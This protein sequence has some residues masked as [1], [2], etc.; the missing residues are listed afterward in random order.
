MV[1]EWRSVIAVSPNIGGG[2]HLIKSAKL[3]MCTQKHYNHNEDGRTAPGVRGHG[4]V[5]QSHSENVVTRGALIIW[6]PN[7]PSQLSILCPNVPYQGSKFSFRQ[8]CPA[9]QVLPKIHSSLRKIYLP[10]FSGVKMKK[11]LKINHCFIDTEANG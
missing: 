8:T 9:G 11:K 1:S 3:F 6:C 4:S 10:C 2:V 7:V 5:P